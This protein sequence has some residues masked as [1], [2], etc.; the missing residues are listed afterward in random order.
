MTAQFSHWPTYAHAT[1]SVFLIGP[2]LLLIFVLVTLTNFM[3]MND[4]AALMI[5]ALCNIIGW[6]ALVEGIML[7]LRGVNFFRS[8]KPEK[9]EPDITK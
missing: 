8:K 2:G 3:D 6:V 7:I 4:E 9:H 5:F 1:L